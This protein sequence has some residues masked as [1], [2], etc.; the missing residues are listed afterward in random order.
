MRLIEL[1]I[2]A[3]LIKKA[4]NTYV[5]GFYMSFYQIDR[6]KF[7]IYIIL[8]DPAPAECG[9][10]DLVSDTGLNLLPVA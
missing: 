5:V 6:S 9:Q 4:H 8:S 7:M 3:K 1:T 10:I 2:F